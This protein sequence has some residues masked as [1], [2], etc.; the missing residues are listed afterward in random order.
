MLFTFDVIRVDLEVLRNPDT[1]GSMIK[2][3]HTAINVS[4]VDAYYQFYNSLYSNFL[5]T[6][7]VLT[8]EKR[9]DMRE[10]MKEGMKEDL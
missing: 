3:T 8:G 5:E 6:I 4:D 9:V 10:K 1:K 7:E 2:W